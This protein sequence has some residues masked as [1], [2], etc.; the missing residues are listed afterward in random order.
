[1]ERI[2]SH[3][4]QPEVLRELFAALGNDPFVIAECLA[5]P[6]LAER[7][8]TNWY[9]ND[10]RIHGKLK[11]RAEADL[12]AHR[13]VSQMRQT[14][15]TYTEVEWIKS[16]SAKDGS[17]SADDKSAQAV[18]MNGSEWQE[19]V[20]KLSAMFGNGPLVGAVD[21]NR[22]A[23]SGSPGE[24]DRHAI[25]KSQSEIIS[26][27]EPPLLEKAAPLAQIR[28]GVLSPLQEDE[29]HYYAVAV[30]KKGKDRLKLATVAWL[31]E[32]LRSWLAKA[33]A[34]AP[35]TMA[36]VSS[37]Y[38]LP[39]ISSPSVACVENTWRPTAGSGPPDAR[40]THTAVWT[41]SEMI[42]W[43]G[44]NGILAFNTGAIPY[45]ERLAALAPASPPTLKIHR[46]HLVGRSAAPSAAQVTRFHAA[47]APPPL[48]SQSH[49]FQHPFERTLAG[50]FPMPPQ[51]ELTNFTRPPA[52]MR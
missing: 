5:R 14:S 12:L 42:V 49:S 4:K 35:V 3:T 28:T 33:E 16:D 21:L 15:G 47:A 13:S 2:A 27:G 36:V 46:P 9:G 37:N 43:G 32:P 20:A 51:I 11:Q 18:K 39:A 23:G 26:S 52:Q 22:P 40:Y 41:G 25:D 8:L 24:I 1:M 6:A 30:M 50:H 31:K 45:S 7:L 38:A 44:F 17:A 19:S 10:Q 29:G 34:Q 48:L